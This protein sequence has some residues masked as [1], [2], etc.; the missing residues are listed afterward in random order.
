MIRPTYNCAQQE[1]YTVC[2]VAYRSCSTQLADFSAFKGKY[3]AAYVTARLAEVEAAAKL[4]DDQA[5]GEKSEVQRIQLLEKAATCTNL[6]QRLKR[7]IADAFPANL[8]KARTDSAGQQHYEKAANQNWDSVNALNTS[9][10]N[11]ITDHLTE[12]TANQNMPATFQATFAT[13]KTAFETLHT[14]FL[15]EEGG[16]PTE[17]QTKITANNDIHTKLM[18][19][20]LDGQEIFRNNEALQK[21]FIFSELLYLA[22]GA[23]TAG[24]K[25]YITA[26]ATT[27]PIEGVLVSIAGTKKSTLT[28][29]EGRYEILQVAA[30]TYTIKYEKTGYTPI[31][32]ENHEVKVGTTSTVSKTMDLLP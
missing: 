30:A 3:N 5:R 28:D 17:T 26:T 15:S 20:L 32:V 31:I 14:Q 22:S 12:L 4:P 10:S 25:G 23:G 7:Y 24:I 16:N 9:A 1:L 18:S 6:F 13:A 11:F 21:Q 29:S 27:F 8:Q 2:R 19:M